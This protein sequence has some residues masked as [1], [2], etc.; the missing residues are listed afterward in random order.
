[1]PI[2]MKCIIMLNFR[3]FDNFSLKLFNQRIRFYFMNKAKGG[4]IGGGIATAVIIGVILVVLTSDD[5]VSVDT[6][7]ISD[8][9]ILNEGGP[10]DTVGINE[11]YTIEKGVEYFINENGTKTYVIVASDSPDLGD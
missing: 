4:A 10:G 8:S 11:S 5:S 2:R 7:E 1:M 3:Y 6:P 9:S